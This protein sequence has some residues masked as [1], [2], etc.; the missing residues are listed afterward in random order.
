[1]ITDLIAVV[2][3]YKTRPEQCKTLIAL[4]AA[5]TTS[6]TRLEVV[7][8]DNSA[9]LDQFPADH[10]EN[11]QISYYPDVNNSGVSKAYNYGYSV[12]VERGKNWILLLDQDTILPENALAK[13]EEAITAFTEEVLF[14]PV[15]ITGD[16]KIISPCDFKYMRGFYAKDF[17]YGLNQLEGRSLVNSGLCMRVT[18]FASSGGYND[19]IKLDYSDHDFVRRFALRVSQ[20][21]VLINLI[22]PHDLSTD[23]T[24]T[25][26]SDKHR[27]SYYLEGSKHFQYN[28]SSS[29]LLKSNNLYR[30]L[31]LSL[32]HKDVYFVR[33]YINYIF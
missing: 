2:V 29:I 3:L 31:K 17:K 4:N 6:S 23:T 22:V 19:L 9:L 12:A 15:M 20:Q 8:Y 30:A 18:A 7:V 32:I 28:L 1:M 26:E 21:F 5:L 27:F 33:K 24:N 16:G 13:Y 14:A 25:L 10:F 11:L